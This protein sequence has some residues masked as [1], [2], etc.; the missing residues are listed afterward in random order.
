MRFLLLWTSLILT[1]C[2]TQHLQA[3]EIN[4]FQYGL[5]ELLI[6][7]SERCKIL[8]EEPNLAAALVACEEAANQGNPEAQ[9]LLGELYLIGQVIP[10]DYNKAKHWFEQA[11]TN[12]H[13]KAQYQLAFMYY[14]GEGMKQDYTQAYIMMKMAAVNGYTEAIDVS[15]EIGSLMDRDQRA[16]AFYTLSKIFQDYAQHL[17]QSVPSRLDLQTKPQG[18]NHNNIIEAKPQD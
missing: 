16:L 14:R 6:P 9:F 11:S 15:D 4:R 5:N 10:Q 12:G 1:L 3:T 8:P 7:A 2:V 18:S 17:K 13:A